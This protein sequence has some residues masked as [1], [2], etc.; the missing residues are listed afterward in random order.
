[1]SEAMFHLGVPTTRALALVLTGDRVVRDMFYNGNA[2][3]EPGA[4]VCR[5]AP[6]LLPPPPLPPAF[7]SPSPLPPPPPNPT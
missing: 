2:K 4:T 5:V 3:E 1:M 7:P 6:R